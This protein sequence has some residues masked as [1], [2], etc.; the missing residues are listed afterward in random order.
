MI[1]KKGSIT[2]VGLGP[3]D[4]ELL[5]IKGY[6]ALKNADVIFYPAS[7]V[8]GET[9]TSFSLPILDQLGLAVRLEPLHI[10][11]KSKDRD[12]FY[13]NA[14]E[15]L[16]KEYD[17]GLNVAVVSE[18]DILFYSTFGYLWRHIM[19]A[20]MNYSLIPGIPAFIAA[21]SLGTLPLVEGNNQLLII[22]CPH[23]FDEITRQIQPD[24]TLVIMK[25]SK[26]ESWGVFLRKLEKPFL[27]VERAGLETQYVTNNAADLTF[28]RIP[29][30]SLLI[31]YG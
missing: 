8:N 23:H 5:T 7:E 31:I 16:K 10:P 17:A 25:L 11:M 20:G 22:S 3:G 2:A 26:L 9:V 6:N 29:Y 14:F 18:G 24:R 4:A 28:R 21:N 1:N 30:F 19:D 12:T 27:Y 15:Q 13:R